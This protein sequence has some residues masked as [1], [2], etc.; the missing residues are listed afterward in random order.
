MNMK[1]VLKLLAPY[2]AV[3]VFWCGLSSAWLAILAYHVQ[4]VLWSRE[5][6]FD[7]RALVR[8]RLVLLALPAAAAGPLL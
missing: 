6:L 8:K 2:F 4:I 7:M 1:T 5:S 3:G